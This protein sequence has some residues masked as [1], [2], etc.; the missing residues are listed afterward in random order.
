MGTPAGG[1]KGLYLGSGEADATGVNGSA[2]V[3][4]I[5]LRPILLLDAAA[6]FTPV[7]TASSIVERNDNG[8]R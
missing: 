5:G 8:S 6:P 4:R 1:L 7:A 3:P 2:A